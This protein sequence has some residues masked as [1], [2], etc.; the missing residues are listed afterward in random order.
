[1]INKTKLLQ[2]LRTPVIFIQGIKISFINRIQ[3]VTLTVRRKI[4]ILYSRSWFHYYNAQFRLSAITKKW[5]ERSAVFL[6]IMFSG[7]ALW[8][9]PELEPYVFDFAD[10]SHLESLQQLVV[11]LGAS[12]IGATTIA[13]SAVMFAMQTNVERMPHSLFKKFGSDLKLL[14]AFITTFIFSISIAVTSIFIQKIGVSLSLAIVIIATL[15]VLGLFY[16][17]IDVRSILSIRT[18]N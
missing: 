17:H 4:S 12:L 1:M 3:R 7:L 5:T 9:S 15:S 2:A 16:I 10:S 8:F 6:F 13:F 11:T 18:N 14:A